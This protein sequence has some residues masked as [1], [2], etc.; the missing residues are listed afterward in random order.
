[1][2]VMGLMSGT[3]LD[4]IDVCLLEV[5][6]T[7]PLRLDW[8]LL[9]FRTHLYGAGDRGLLRSGIEEGDAALLCR[10]HGLLAEGMARAVLALLDEVGVGPEE[11]SAIGSHGQTLWH[12]PPTPEDGGGDGHGPAGGPAGGADIL[13]GP[14][15]RGFTL[16]LGDPATLAERTGIDV[17]SDFRSRDVAAGGHG[18][19]LVPWADR[20]LLSR[21]GTARVLQNLGGMGNL[22]WIP[23]R[24][25]T[26]PLLAFDTGPGVALMDAAVALATRELRSFD[27]DGVLARRGRVDSG[28]L[29]RLLEDPFLR[30]PPPRSTGREHFG[31]AMVAR[32]AEERG[33][34]PGREE[35]GWPDLLATLAAL[36]ARSVAEAIQGW[37]LP[38]P[39][40]EVVLA[41][42]GSSNP[43][44]VEALTEL[45][46][47][48]PVRTGAEA[49]GIDPDAKEAAAFALMAWAHLLRIPANV[50]EATGARGLRV[51]GSLTP[52]RR[53]APSTGSRP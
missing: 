13:V 49:L 44:L 1:M 30:R 20:A 2:K 4:G 22:A 17:V 26:E 47:P 19:P 16:Q 5:E 33:L 10:I 42:G 43:V 9:G 6:G 12:Q 36:T 34:V 18:A 23:P 24:G 48:I 52:G 11:V 28:L 32:L 14:P 53:A 40:D 38:R 50:P 25:S 15:G 8:R 35:E 29:E 41:G 39:V 31:S 46:A 7:D 45:L 27:E 21:P 3:S 51:L 37:V